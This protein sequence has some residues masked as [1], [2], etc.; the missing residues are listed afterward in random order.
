[1]AD[2]H[3][4]KVGGDVQRIKSTFIDL[5][6]ISGTFSFA[7]AGDF[8]INAPNRYRQNFQSAST[9]RNAYTGLFA[10]DEWRLRSNLTFSYGL[11]WEDESILS[12]L[13]NFAPRIAA[14]YDPFESGRQ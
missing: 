3:S 10:Q 14:A 7:S 8:L 1:M 5:S 2:E 12:D 11:R 4:L 9:Q 13:N 6:D